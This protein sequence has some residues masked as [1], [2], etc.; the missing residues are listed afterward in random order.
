MFFIS[1]R[2]K[3]THIDLD[4]LYKLYTTEGS[5]IF[6][7]SKNIFQKWARGIKSVFNPKY[8]PDGL[9]KL[10]T[11]YFGDLTIKSSLK[12][13]IVSSYDLKSNEIIMFKSRN[14]NWSEERFDVK[15]KDVCRATSAAPTYLPSYEMKFIILII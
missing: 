2:E 5:T 15:L 13:I 14:A 11:Q 3:K 7:Q 10:L 1:V 4:T 12:P 6:P 8:S 9:D